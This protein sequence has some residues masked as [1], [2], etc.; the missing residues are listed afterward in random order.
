MFCISLFSMMGKKTVKHST[1]VAA[2]V[3]P[4]G[5]QLHV[6]S[7]FSGVRYFYSFQGSAVSFLSLLTLR[8]RCMCQ[9]CKVLIPFHSS[10]KSICFAI[11]LHCN[12]CV[13]G[14]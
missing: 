6:I 8:C 7:S 13:D 1:G 3:I 9:N 14:K 11:I 4:G 5:L 2:L 10:P 12:M